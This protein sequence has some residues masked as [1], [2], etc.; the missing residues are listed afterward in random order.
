VP[1]WLKVRKRLLMLFVEFL[2]QMYFKIFNANVTT[3]G[4]CIEFS[5]CRKK[6]LIFLACLH[7]F[8]LIQWL[9]RMRELK[10]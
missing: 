9:G 10:T 5:S 8:V 3:E 2:I 1:Q 6:R 7:I 4:P